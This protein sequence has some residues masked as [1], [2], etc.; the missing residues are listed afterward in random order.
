MASSD[1]L[2]ADHACVRQRSERE[3]RGTRQ[4]TKERS[5]HLVSLFLQIQ[6]PGDGKRKK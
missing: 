1:L 5:G 2:G 4:G 3:Y 6:K